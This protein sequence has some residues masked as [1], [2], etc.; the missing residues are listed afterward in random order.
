MVHTAAGYARMK[1]RLGALVCTTS[2]GPGA[3]NMVTGAALATVNRLPVLLLPGR[4]LRVPRA[5][6]PCCSSS[7]RPGAATCRSTTASGPSR[8]TSTGSS[9]R[10]SSISAALRGDARARRTGRDRRRD[11]RAS[12]RTS[13]PRPT[14][15]PR[16]F[17]EKRVWHDPAAACPTTRRSRARPRLIRARRR[18][19]IVAGGGVIYCE[20]TEALRALRASRRA[21]RSA[22][23]R[24][25][26]GSLPYDH[27]PRSA[28][29][30]RPGR[31]RPTGSPR[32]ADLVIGIGTRWSDFTT[33][34]KTAFAHPDVRFV[35]VNVADFDAAKHAGSPLVGDARATLERL[36]GAARGLVGG[37]TP[38]AA[39][40]A[41][42][43]ARVGRRGRAPVRARPRD[44]CPRR[45]R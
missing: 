38:T 21:S 20:A 24:P 26:K 22:R 13:R 45:A 30:A 14:T 42:L 29:S 39:E 27:P 11:A 37:A 8:A 3:T 5:P 2:I 10:S 6:T 16:R 35:N 12:R 4:R 28:R 25:G 36:A 40:A 9:A 17:L 19:L 34:S 23:R 32:E 15:S 7:S 33:A 31:S 43:N 1:N 41:Q 44:R 18:P